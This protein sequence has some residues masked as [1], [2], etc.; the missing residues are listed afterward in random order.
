M[1]R[2]KGFVSKEA[3]LS[4]LLWENWRLRERLAGE[5]LLFE[6]PATEW[7]LTLRFDF[8][9]SWKNISW[10]FVG[11]CEYASSLVRC[12]FLVVLSRVLRFLRDTKHRVNKVRRRTKTG[13]SDCETVFSFRRRSFVEHADDTEGGFS[14]ELC[15]YNLDRT[16]LSVFVM[17]FSIASICRLRTLFSAAST[18]CRLRILLK[19]WEAAMEDRCDESIT[20]CFPTTNC[21]SGTKKMIKWAFSPLCTTAI[22]LLRTWLWKQRN[23]L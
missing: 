14:E 6:E 12:G 3:L 23:V 9:C 22:S 15:E 16:G 13:A 8:E 21:Y 1:Y 4:L 20:L 7:P 5:R 2:L 17:V 18:S 10:A 11:M 19:W